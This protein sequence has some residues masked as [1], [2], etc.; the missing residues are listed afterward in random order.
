MGTV[1]LLR[2]SVD[3]DR[4]YA[5]CDRVVQNENHMRGE[6]RNPIGN[7]STAVNR[8][9]CRKYEWGWWAAGEPKTLSVK[10][11][12]HRRHSIP[13]RLRVSGLERARPTDKGR[14][15]L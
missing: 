5:G 8:K 14:L 4:W 10:G 12:P 2:E 6:T 13:K 11:V 15:G 9:H 1:Q 3:D 7:N